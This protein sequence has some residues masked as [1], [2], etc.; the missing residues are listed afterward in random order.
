MSNKQHVGG[1]SD[2]LVEDPDVVAMREALANK[3]AAVKPSGRRFTGVSRN[4][5][6]DPCPDPECRGAAMYVLNSGRQ[7]CP[8][9]RHDEERIRPES[10]GGAPAGYTGTTAGEAGDLPDLSYLRIEV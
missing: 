4:G 10:Y 7:W 8:D 2:A 3:R 6:G 1:L 9:Q 5:N